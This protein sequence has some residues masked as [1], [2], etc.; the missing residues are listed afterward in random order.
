MRCSCSSFWQI[1]KQIIHVNLKCDAKYEDKPLFIPAHESLYL[2][3][4]W[5][6][7]FECYAF[8]WVNRT[9]VKQTNDTS[10]DMTNIIP[11]NF[12]SALFITEIIHIAAA[13]QQ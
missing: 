6:F 12:Q 8:T 7:N 5:S 3:A 1:P 13:L 10:P 9:R 2:A 11:I 4:V